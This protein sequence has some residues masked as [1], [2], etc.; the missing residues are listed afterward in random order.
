MIQS[1]MICIVF[2]YHGQEDFSHPD[3]RT[4]YL[5]GLAKHGLTFDHAFAGAADPAESRRIHL[6]GACDPSDTPSLPQQ[7]SAVGFETGFVGV[8]GHAERSL[9]SLDF[10]WAEDFAPNRESSDEDITTRVGDQAVRFLQSVC[11]PFFLY[12][13][14][15]SARP[16]KRSRAVADIAHLDTQIG[17]IL[18]TLSSRG[19]TNTTIFYA[20]LRGIDWTHD[21]DYPWENSLRVPFIVSGA[22]GQRHGETESALISTADLMPTILELCNLDPSRGITGGSVGKHIF[23]A[24]APSRSNVCAQWNAC[25]RYGRNARYKLIES[26]EAGRS[27]LYDIQTDPEEN[28]NL[29]GSPKHI[30]HQVKLAQAIRASL[31]TRTQR[32]K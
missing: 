26:T 28:D 8:W 2:P 9:E 18:A 16:Q 24:Q 17:R 4:P 19:H 14:F 32:S 31:D 13:S 25:T 20:G 10:D 12:A 23:D 27:A 3:I 11:S 1:N 7:L 15:D 21:S 22:P 5:N 6:L 29:L 30:A